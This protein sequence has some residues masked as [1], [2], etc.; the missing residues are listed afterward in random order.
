MRGRSPNA[1]SSSS[2]ARE[3]PRRSPSA[4]SKAAFFAAHHLSMEIDAENLKR[5][6]GGGSNGDMGQAKHESDSSGEF[7]HHK[8]RGDESLITHT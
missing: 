5:Q 3:H 6:R 1:P 7:R 2:S 4:R 8:K